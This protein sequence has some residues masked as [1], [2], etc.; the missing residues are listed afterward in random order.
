MMLLECMAATD[1]FRLDYN[2]LELE[3][4]AGDFDHSSGEISKLSNT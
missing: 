4:F 2:V 1:H 3:L